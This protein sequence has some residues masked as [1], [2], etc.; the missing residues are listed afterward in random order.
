MQYLV[1]ATG[2]KCLKRFSKTSDFKC[3]RAS[4]AS[5]FKRKFLKAI[6]KPATL[7]PEFCMLYQKSSCVIANCCCHKVASKVV[8]CN[9]D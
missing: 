8:L 5:D 7:L 4:K 6:Q 2:C 1:V 3:K 9:M